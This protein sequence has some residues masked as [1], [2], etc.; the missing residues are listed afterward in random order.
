MTTLRSL[1]IP[2]YGGDTLFCNTASAYR[3]LPEYLRRLADRL[4]AVHSNVYDYGEASQNRTSETL[5]FQK[6]FAIKSY[7]TAHPVVSVNLAS[8]APSL[9]IGGF[10]SELIGLSKTES[11]DILR[12]LQV[13]VTGP[14]NMLRHRWAVGDVLA[15][16]NRSTQHYAVDDYG[17]LP[18]RMHRVTA[19]GD[20]PVGID[21]TRSYIIEGDPAE[22]YTP[23][24]G[25]GTMTRPDR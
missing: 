16:D 15:W 17:D 14:E 19:A 24:P 25:A 18:R 3:D 10:T 6:K 4:W 11:R 22:H 13:Y 23:A 9:F 2:P 7:R 1:E 5:D 12:L 21:G 20:V 8:G